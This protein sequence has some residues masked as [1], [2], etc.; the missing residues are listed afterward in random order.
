MEDVLH[1]SFALN[2]FEIQ[3]LCPE[4]YSPILEPISCPDSLQFDPLQ[5]TI[6]DPAS[7]DHH[8]VPEPMNTD[9][10]LPQVVPKLDTPSSSRPIESLSIWLTD[11][12]AP[13][14]SPKKRARRQP[15]PRFFTFSEADIQASRRGQLSMANKA[16]PAAFAT[17]TADETSPSTNFEEEVSDSDYESR[18][19]EPEEDNAAGESI[20]KDRSYTS[21]QYPH[22]GL[23]YY[24]GFLKDRGDQC[25]R[26]EMHSLPSASFQTT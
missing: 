7:F 20:P 4:F 3:P 8:F 23:D 16:A 11:D 1:S 10:L 12:V 19:D 21:G 2:K 13:T 22:E 17:T 6:E 9:E 15:V 5:C 18:E 14:P 25:S 24:F 26:E